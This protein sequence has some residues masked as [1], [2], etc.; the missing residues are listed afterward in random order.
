MR[1]S[2]YLKITVLIGVWLLPFGGQY[3]GDPTDPADP[4]RNLVVSLINNWWGIL[5][6]FFACFL[7][8]PTV[9][10]RYVFPAKCNLKRS[11]LEVFITA[12]FFQ[13]GLTTIQVTTLSAIYQDYIG[14][15]FPLDEE[16]ISLSDI[17]YSYMVRVGGALSILLG[18][19]IWIRGKLPPRDSKEV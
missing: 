16:L 18:A 1:T 11:M 7:L 13:W 10:L 19:I 9:I 14:I 6:I 2:N 15:V 5:A 12:A 4:V 3:Y 17:R 8:I